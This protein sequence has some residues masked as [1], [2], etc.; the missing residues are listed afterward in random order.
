V[1]PKFGYHDLELSVP[2]SKFALFPWEQDLLVGYP[3][4]K[5]MPTRYCK[6]LLRILVEYRPAL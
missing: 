3:Q 6:A 1:S 5:Q 2:V 4:K